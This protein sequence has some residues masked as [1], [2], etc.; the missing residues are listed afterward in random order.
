MTPTM[1][2]YRN[3]VLLHNL[4]NIKSFSIS[5]E[6]VHPLLTYARVFYCQERNGA[7]GKG[8]RNELR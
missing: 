2:H 4:Q 5:E 8:E 6:E 3:E 1:Q 7:K